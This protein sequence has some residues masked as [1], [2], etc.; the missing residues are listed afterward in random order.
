MKNHRNLSFLVLA[1]LYILPF[2]AEA[3]L[4]ERA[5][6]DA[7]RKVE[8]KVTDVI[9]DKGTDLIAREFGKRLDNWADKQMRE[10]YEKDSTYASKGQFDS[11]TYAS[12][13]TYNDFLGAM[14]ASVDIP[15]SYD[16][17]RTMLIETKDSKEK[18]TLT[19]M[20]FNSET[21][22]FGMGMEDP[23]EAFNL[24]VYDIANDISVI[25]G[26]DREGNKT[27]MAMPNMMKVGMSLMTS[28]DKEELAV[29]Y[30]YKKTGKTEV[31]AGYN[32]NEYIGED[33]DHEYQVFITEEL[34]IRWSEAYFEV[35]KD[36][37]PDIDQSELPY[38]NSF[39]MRSIGTKKKNGKMSHSWEVQSVSKDKFSINNA[40]YKKINL[41]E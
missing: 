25:Y 11:M 6:K 34:N 35:L 29:A 38:E 10:A 7:V 16:F 40:D 9:I 4:L 13:R 19:K 26:E 31:I 5:L 1:L 23:N 36:I 8:D 33:E 37:M 30:N 32:C 39:S 28:A 22:V 24:F 20:Y 14:T 21:A 18:T 3:Q 17:D 41:G 2:S 15:S 12:A 27:V